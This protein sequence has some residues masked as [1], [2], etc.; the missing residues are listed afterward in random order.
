[1]RQP[2]DRVGHYVLRA[3]LG[4]GGMGE[5]YE[6]EDVR[7]GR[8]VA[9]KLI[10]SG[11]DADASERMMREARAAAGFEHRNVVLVLDV[12]VVDEGEGIGQTYLA[13]ELVRGRTMRALIRD[14]SVPLARK[15]RWLVDT[16]RAL[17]AGHALGLVHRDIKPDNLMVRED[18]LIKVLD[19]GIAKKARSV[20]P[21]APTEASMDVG[22]L[23]KAGS[24]VGTPRYA[25]PEQL[26]GEALDGRADQYAWG[27]TAY[28]LLSGRPPFEADD[29]VALLSRVLTSEAPSLAVVAPDVPPEV[30]AAVMRAI[31]KVPADRFASLDDAADAIEPFAEAEFASADRS[32]RITQAPPATERER[33]KSS[34]AAAKTAPASVVVRA[35]KTSFRVFFWIAA[36]I[37]TLLIAAL[38]VGA[39]TGTLRV[40]PPAPSAAA[41]ASAGA[42]AIGATSIRCHDAEV[43]GA[44]ASPELAHMLGV[45]ACARLA[46]T[47]GRAWGHEKALEQG[48]D[49]DESPSL[50]AAVTLGPTTHVKLT[51]G[52]LQ[53]SADA[54]SPIEAVRLAVAELAPKLGTPPTSDAMRAAWGAAT[55]E[56]ARR[57]ERVWRALLVGDLKDPE[58]EARALVKSD[59][60]SPW[61]YAILGIVAVRGSKTCLD[62]LAEAEKRLDK[63][64]GARKRGLGALVKLLSNPKPEEVMR[65]LRKAYEDAP[66][67]ADIAG[68]YAAI[69]ISLVPSEEGFAV[70]DRLAERFPTRAILA[71]Q[72]AVTAAPR[73]DVARDD[74]YLGRLTEI[75]P[76]AACDDIV[77]DQHLVKGDVEGARSLLGTCRAYFGSAS[78]DRGLSLKEARVDLV[79]GEPEKAHALAVKRLGD[80]RAA[81]RAEAAQYVI[82]SF[83]IAGRVTEAEDTLVAELKRERDSESS[84][85][86]LR[87]AQALLRLH[88]RLGTKPPEEILSWFAEALPKAT[89]LPEHARLALEV[90]LSLARPKDTRYAD[91]VLDAIA[92]LRDPGA[93]L[94]SL[95]LARARKGDK[96]AVE[97]L[98]ASSRAS[99]G[100]RLLSAI[101]GALAL[102]ATKAD[103]DEVDRTLAPL[104][105]PD[106]IAGLGLDRT[107]ADLLMVRAY[108]AAKRPEDAARAKAAADRAL[109]HAD[110]GV[111]EALEKLE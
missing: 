74:H 4:Q 81:V 76:E 40:G 84:L 108:Q 46:I 56:S 17:A 14:A 72:N 68:L 65:E 94:S 82:G 45:G 15:V 1:M 3:L 102:L 32:G 41:S 34:A 28:E 111:R 16:A 106:G 7:L 51:L 11:A 71:I 87:H 48:V 64:E 53:A 39:V 103:P 80:P 24:I 8:R 49:L 107:L 104:R 9:L 31:A 73:R 60:D 58:G 52:A 101:D 67:D 36:T 77:I 66:D 78:E 38:V 54:T 22:T 57:I 6:A 86:A 96:V 29:P 88:R 44:G 19:F 18:G 47:T 91:E 69:A 23:T 83:L 59:P 79:A 10:P 30:A 61:S 26:R 12:G 21:S 37:G 93:T 25:P 55:P 2:G 97:I 89:Y 33:S 90:E 63:L 100:P 50:D 110:A 35:A 109:A 62:A 95:P 99:D 20:D 105:T 85:L 27:A 98:R 5:V 13:M 42:T 70:V 75:V 43:S 92:K